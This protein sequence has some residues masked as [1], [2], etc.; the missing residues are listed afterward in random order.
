MTTAEGSILSSPSVQIVANSGFISLTKL[1]MI[2]AK[3]IVSPKMK[4]PPHQK[5]NSIDLSINDCINLEYQLKPMCP[6]HLSS[7]LP[8]IYC[9][10][11]Y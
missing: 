10:V 3:N 8:M 9:L 7:L 2:I 6:M 4:L 5:I 11:L 1:S